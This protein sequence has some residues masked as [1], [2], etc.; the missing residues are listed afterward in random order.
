MLSSKFMV[1]SGKVL[2]GGLQR[3][4]ALIKRFKGLENKKSTKFKAYILIATCTPRPT[5]NDG[6][7]ELVKDFGKPKT[8]FCPAIRVP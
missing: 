6:L 5:L 3:G 4:K 7:K 8:S 2:V 1:S